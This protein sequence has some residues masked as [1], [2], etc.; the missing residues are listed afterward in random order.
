MPTSELHRDHD[1]GKGSLHRAADERDFR[2]SFS[3]CVE[4]NKCRVRVRV[5]VRVKQKKQP[6]SSER[7]ASSI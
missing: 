5:R 3:Q 1:M 6:G 4:T 2:D 7:L